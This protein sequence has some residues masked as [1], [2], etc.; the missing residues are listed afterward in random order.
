MRI[1]V[2]RDHDPDPKK[3]LRREVWVFDHNTYVPG[4]CMRLCSY[5][6]ETRKS[7]RC[8]VWDVQGVWPKSHVDVGAKTLLQPEAIP[9]DVVAEVKQR[10]FDAFTVQIGW[11]R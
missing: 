3:A 8:R 5:Y 4:F 1:E 11:P 2:T 6:V 9:D 10:L 7:T